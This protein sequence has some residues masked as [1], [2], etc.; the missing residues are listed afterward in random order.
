MLQ[1]APGWKKDVIKYSVKKLVQ[2]LTGGWSMYP[3]FHPHST[4]VTIIPTGIKYVWIFE[5]I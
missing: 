5:S 3:P 2:K 4:S 1:I